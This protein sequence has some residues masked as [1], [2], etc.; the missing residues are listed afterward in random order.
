MKSA[1]NIL[2]RLRAVFLAERRR[3]FLAI[4]AYWRIYQYAFHTGGFDD[5]FSDF[6]GFCLRASFPATGVRAAPAF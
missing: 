5:G 2:G 6:D 3:A 4:S 1:A